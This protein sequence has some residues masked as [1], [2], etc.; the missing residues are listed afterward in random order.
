[1]TNTLILS[2]VAWADIIICSTLRLAQVAAGVAGII[3]MVVM[4]YE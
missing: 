3:V 2:A 4:A 1:M